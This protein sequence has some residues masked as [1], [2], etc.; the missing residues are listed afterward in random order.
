MDLSLLILAKPLD[1]HGTTLA[2]IT[3]PR[4]ISLL[5]FAMFPEIF[6]HVVGGSAFLKFI[7]VKIPWQ[8]FY[9]NKSKN[10]Q[11]EKENESLTT[12]VR[13]ESLTWPSGCPRTS[14][15]YLLIFL[16]TFIGGSSM[17]KLPLWSLLNADDIL[18]ILKIRIALLFS[19]KMTE[20][21]FNKF[22]SC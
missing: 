18:T 7:A 13:N 11:R 12:C 3:Y 17:P 22:F 1:K 14:A 6:T 8:S 2:H 10:Q 5:I 9:K 21:E 15:M 4:L 16:S 19:V 20:W